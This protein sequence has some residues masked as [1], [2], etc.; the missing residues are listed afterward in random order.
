MPKFSP[1]N[2]KNVWGS[3]NSISSIKPYKSQTDTHGTTLD[4]RKTPL[5]MDVKVGKN[6]FC[7]CCHILE[8]NLKEDN[9]REE[10]SMSLQ[11]IV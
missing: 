10:A 1:N 2:C 6:L 11:L 7:N 8:D 4:S 9:G 3:Q 5:S